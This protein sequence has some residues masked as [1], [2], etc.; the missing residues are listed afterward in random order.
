[1]ARGALPKVNSRQKGKVG[2]LELAAFLREHGFDEAKRGV[3]YRGG[4]DS[5]DVV[6][7]PGFHVECKRVEAGNLYHWLDQA[8]A[9]SDGTGRVPVVAHRRNRRQWVAILP[10]DEFLKIIREKHLAEPSCG[11]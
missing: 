1:M 11:D 3:Q 6:G 7:L 5:P 2:E 10:L 4:G 9:D 8:Y